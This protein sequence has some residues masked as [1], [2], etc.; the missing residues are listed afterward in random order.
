MKMLLLI[1]TFANFPLFYGLTITLP[2]YIQTK[3]DPADFTVC[4]HIIRVASQNIT[5]FIK[6]DSIFA[7]CSALSYGS[8]TIAGTKSQYSLL[9]R[10]YNMK[11]SKTIR[12][13]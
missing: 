8:K 9:G 13:C 11:S 2:S 3:G 6:T 5:S 4:A 12:R 1:L 10:I 7:S